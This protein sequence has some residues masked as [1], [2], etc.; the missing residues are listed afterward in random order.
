MDSNEEGIGQK[1]QKPMTARILS[2]AVSVFKPTE[3]KYS[4]F[5]WSHLIS[6]YS[7]QDFSNMVSGA[8]KGLPIK[9]PTIPIKVVTTNG[10][11]VSTIV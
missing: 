2:Q 6:V 9:V 1:D 8:H 7:W 11:P 3:I 5:A 4:T 10:T